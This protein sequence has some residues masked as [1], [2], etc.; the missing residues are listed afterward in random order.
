MPVW[1]PDEFAA[2]L[3]RRVSARRKQMRDAAYEVTLRGVHE[4][5]EVTEKLGIVD[6][7]TYKQRFKARRTKTGATL[8][9]DA[10]HAAVIEFGRR[11][12]AR[13]PPLGSIIGWVSRKLGVGGSAGRS[14]A[15]VIA[16]AIGRRGLP[17]YA[18][19]RRHLIPKLTTWYRAK[20]REMVRTKP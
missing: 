19:F 10:P 8:S 4:G 1:T 3:G 9:N 20:L 14:L 18:V 17:A 15:Y 12:G 2:E 6:R 11:A 16:R 5:A 13:R 7:G